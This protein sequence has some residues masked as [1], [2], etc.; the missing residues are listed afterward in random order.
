MQWRRNATCLYK[1]ALGGAGLSPAPRSR[2]RDDGQQKSGSVRRIVKDGVGGASPLGGSGRGFARVQIAIETREIAAGN[3]QA[4]AMACAK[5]VAG[6]PEIDSE[7]V[8]LARR[9]E[10][11][12]SCESRYFARRIPSVM[13]MAEPSG[14]TSTSLPV[15]SVSTADEEAK[16]SR[17]TGPVASRS[18][19]SGGVE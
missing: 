1:D 11:G 16:N 7:G 14:E 5:N 18:C 15:K 13:F 6:G 17:R 9:E 3:F 4:D 19:S 12:V 10:C 8:D 2:L